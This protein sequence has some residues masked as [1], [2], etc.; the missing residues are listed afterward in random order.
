[1]G[2]IEIEEESEADHLKVDGR[3][4]YSGSCF[5]YRLYAIAKIGAFW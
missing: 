4:L 5:F 1:M 3:V 2:K